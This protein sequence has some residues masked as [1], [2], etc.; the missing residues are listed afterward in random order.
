MSQYHTGAC[1]CACV[2][3][4]RWFSLLLH[5]MLNEH[6]VYI[7]A[8]YFISNDFISNTRLRFGVLER[9]IWRNNDVRLYNQMLNDSTA[10]Q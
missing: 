8:F 9:K 3:V 6:D 5:I 2:C 1:A 4:A 10:S 7:H